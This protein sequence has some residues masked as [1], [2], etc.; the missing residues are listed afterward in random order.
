[1]PQGARPGR[2][3]R[4][5]PAP[6]AGAVEAAAYA[7]AYR[8]PSCKARAAVTAGLLAVL[9]RTDCP[10]Y[11]PVM[12]PP[13]RQRGRPAIPAPPPARFSPP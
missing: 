7:A 12:V 5:V 6:P 3:P 8:C 11:R 13:A 4:L 1:M 9:H 10:R 2:G